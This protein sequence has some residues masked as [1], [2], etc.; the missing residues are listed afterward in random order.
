[1]H[2]FIMLN[3]LKNH[4]NIQKDAILLFEVGQA[5]ISSHPNI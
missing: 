2:L 1:M 4:Q 3:V 5:L